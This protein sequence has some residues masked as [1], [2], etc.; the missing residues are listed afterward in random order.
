MTWNLP[1]RLFNS[2]K[3][4]QIHKFHPLNHHRNRS[5]PTNSYKQY[6]RAFQLKPRYIRCLRIIHPKSTPINPS[7]SSQPR[8]NFSNHPVHLA[9]PGHRAIECEW[10]SQDVSIPD[11]GEQTGLFPATRGIRGTC[12]SKIEIV[13]A[14]ALVLEPWVTTVGSSQPL[15]PF[16]PHGLSSW[17]TSFSQTQLSFS[18]DDCQ[19]NGAR[20]FSFVSD[21]DKYLISRPAETYEILSGNF[22]GVG[23]VQ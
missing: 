15:A 2:S 13:R 18:S 14:A 21:S 4:K 7:Y 23:G 5:A 17:S 11:V 9:V 1:S 12:G 8:P 22:Q 16:N 20:H 10:A 6:F 19:P 3:F